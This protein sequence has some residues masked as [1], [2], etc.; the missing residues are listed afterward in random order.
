MARAAAAHRI[1]LAT[2]VAAMLLAAPHAADVA[3]SCGQVN[4]ALSPCILYARGLAAAPSAD[5]CS[6]VKS[7]AT[8]TQT[9][10]PRAT[11]SRWPPAA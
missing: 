11:A 4:A 6:G 1:L 9:G 3:I 10:A 8:A 5:C 7:L 2:L